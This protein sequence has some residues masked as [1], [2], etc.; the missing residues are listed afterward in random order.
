MSNKSMVRY[1]RDSFD[2][3]GDDLCRL[4]LRYLPTDD[5][6]RY[7]CVSKQWQ[8]FIY[9]TVVSF[10]IQP[11]YRT[12]KWQI[13]KKIIKKCP[14][15]T[16]IQS[17]R[18]QNLNSLMNKNIC[19]VFTK[20][21]HHLTNIDIYVEIGLS[22]KL[23]YKLLSK[24]AKQ[25]TSLSIKSLNDTAY[26]NVH[27]RQQFLY[28]NLSFKRLS[29]FK[30][31]YHE[32]DTDWY[33][34]FADKCGQQIQSMDVQIM[35]MDDQSLSQLFIGLSKMPKL[36][37]LCLRR[38]SIS[39]DIPNVNQLDNWLAII[40][41]YFPQVFS[42]Y[43]GNSCGRNHLLTKSHRFPQL[44]HLSIG[45][46]LKLD[47]GFFNNIDNN[48]PKLRYFAAN[49]V[50]ITN[51]STFES[52]SQ[53]KYL[54]NKIF[55]LLL[56]IQCLTQTSQQHNRFKRWDYRELTHQPKPLT[57]NKIKFL[58]SKRFEDRDMFESI[59][60]SILLPR[61]PGTDGHKSVQKFIIKMI[62]SLG[63]S[64]EED[65][66]TSSTPLGRRTF[67]NIM[68]TIEPNH[69][70]RIILSCHYDSKLNREKTFI[71]AIDSAVPCAMILHL[72]LILDKYL[73]KANNE[74]TVQMV[75]FDGEEAMV[76]WSNEDSLY[77]SRH[78][79]NKW[80]H[81]QYPKSMTNM[82]QNSSLGQ[83]SELD[84]IELMVLLDLIGA[85]NPKFYSYFPNTKPLFNR[86][87]EIEKK[88]ND[89]NLME[90]SNSGRKRTS[91]FNSRHP[92]SY[93]EDD[94]VPFLKLNVPVLHMIPTPFPSVWH[95]ESDN[96]ENLNFSTINN[97][98]KIFRIFIAEYLHLNID[99]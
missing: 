35:G 84:R 97:L 48:Y 92:F 32:S 93:I 55:L 96:R 19:N 22:M 67:N 90:I 91:Y 29:T 49:C 46:H 5:R 10:K 20:Y 78:L 86:L 89:L 88:L 81:K 47:D 28:N 85:A 65:K 43:I 30:F 24:F 9:E 42:L 40:G 8:T 53:L 75:F 33:L 58:A 26:A 82:C 2:R 21:N 12:I 70:K 17:S 76:Q 11:I 38:L 23:I 51:K 94:H 59:L 13:L 50:T 80:N 98:M 77:G 36:V 16:H 79:A 61:S 45:G 68:A 72:G 41:A 99:N 31:V 83:T 25:L 64:L 56:C 87:M 74:T 27:L 69:C 71:G 37:E 57:D 63:W 60:D 62:K 54:K 15:I 6:F 7:E 44:T 18:R 4:L 34:L 14:N 1:P 39:F 52:L 73:K 3:F 66:F 95:R